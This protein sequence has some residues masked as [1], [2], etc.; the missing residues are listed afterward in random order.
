MATEMLLLTG[1]LPARIDAAAKSF[2]HESVGTET[3]RIDPDE[4]KPLTPARRA[5]IW[6]PFG[7]SR[8]ARTLPR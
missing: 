4:T 3:E 2:R 1:V 7:G 5:R 6:F 8:T